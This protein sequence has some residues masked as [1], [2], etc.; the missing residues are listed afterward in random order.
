VTGRD[1]IFGGNGSDTIDGGAELDVIF[2]DQGHMSYVARL[3]GH[4]A[5]LATSARSTS[6]R[7]STLAVWGKGDRITDDASD[8]IIFGGQGDD[9]IDAGAGQNIVFGDHGRILGVDADSRL[10]ATACAIVRSAT[11]TPPRP[12]TTTRSRC[13]AWWPRSTGARSTA[14][15]TSS[16][17]ATTRSPPASAA[18]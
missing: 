13:W 10:G 5:D 15:T 2:G 17:T 14:R 9:I 16:A 3:L 7:A 18:T 8:D 4:R 1:R 6:S 12:T 11:R